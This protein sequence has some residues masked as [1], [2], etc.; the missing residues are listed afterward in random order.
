MVNTV[1]VGLFRVAACVHIARG[2]CLITGLLTYYLHGVHNNS[3]KCVSLQFYFV[4]NDAI[5]IL[6]ASAFFNCV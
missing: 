1:E 4:I 3:D 6:N 2:I 5:A